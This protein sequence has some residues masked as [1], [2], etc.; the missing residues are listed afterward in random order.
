MTAVTGEDGGFEMIV[1]EPGGVRVSVESADGRTSYPA[2]GVD[3]PDADAYTLDLAFDLGTVAVVVVDR[4]TDQPVARA[5][6]SASGK[7]SG[8][9]APWGSGG[10]TG[11]DGRFQLELEP[12][13]Y[14]VHAAA[15]N[16][17]SA[18]AETTVAAGGGADLKL[19]L[20]RGL[21]LSGKVVD[22]RGR[23]VGGLTV[24]AMS[25]EGAGRSRAEGF[26]TTL[27]DGTF[28]MGGLRPGPYRV[29]AHS[30]F[31]TFATRSG[32]SPGDKD[33]VLTLRPGGRVAVRVLGV[34]GQPVASVFVGAEGLPIGVA[35]DAQGV[36]EVVVPAGTTE[37]VVHKDRLEGRTTITV[38]E[39][40]TGTAEIRLAPAS[41]G[42][43]P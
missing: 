33:V 8:P 2:R 4:D 16:Y 12:G 5:R 10:Q 35:T 7:K 26:A 29:V 18:E 23:A 36:A 34:D 31:G 6:I 30:D 19:T 32:V 38:G 28:Q 43:S 22:A 17:G 39:G 11:E 37:L 9:D 15:D 41:G 21:P 1:D 20:S 14:V 42:G 13:D 24:Q 25:T 40:G 3:I 27:P